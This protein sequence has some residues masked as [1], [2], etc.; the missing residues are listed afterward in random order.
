MKRPWFIGFMVGAAALLCSAPARA[1]D[2]PVGAARGELETSTGRK[3]AGIVYTPGYRALRLREGE[4]AENLT[5][6]LPD[7]SSIK[8]YVTSERLEQ[9]FLLAE[10]STTERIMLD[11]YFPRIDMRHQVTLRSGRE[12]DGVLVST[13]YVEAD[14]AR[15]RFHLQEKLVGNAGETLDGLIYVSRIVFSDEDASARAPATLRIETNLENP[16]SRAVLIRQSSF[17]KFETESFDSVA[18]F[19]NVVSGVYDLFVE[20]ENRLLVGLGFAGEEKFEEGAELTAEDV[21]SIEARIHE[22]PSFFDEFEILAQAGNRSLAKIVLAS[23]IPVAETSFDSETDERFS[24]RR[25]ELWIL[26][27]GGSRWEVLDRRFLMRDRIDSSR[28]AR[29]LET[30]SG[31]A[32]LAVDISNPES[33]RRTIEVD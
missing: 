11:E 20:T 25:I 30:I 2:I 3:I 23:S 18:T 1:E 6:P 26:C 24:F 8:T 32:N 17:D 16:V 12:F 5:I 14:D 15:E 13:I 29:K 19:E 22:I 10:E 31:F 9:A 27:N 21:S 28:P 7:V 4:S 33:L